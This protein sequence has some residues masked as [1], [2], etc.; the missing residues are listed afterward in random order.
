MREPGIPEIPKAAE[1][2]PIPEPAQA[3]GEPRRPAPLVS[4]PQAAQQTERFPAPI[5][6]PFPPPVAV[7]VPVP[8]QRR[9]SST[10]RQSD[11]QEATVEPS[12]WTPTPEP[13]VRNDVPAHEPRSQADEAADATGNPLNG[14]I[15]AGFVCAGLGLLFMPWLFAIIVFS[16]GQGVKKKSERGS[17]EWLLG[18]VLIGL[19]IL[20][21]VVWVVKRMA[22]TNGL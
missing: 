5:A 9:S 21:I 19:A 1:A 11:W 22:E 10:E 18:N 4:H 7:P 17:G 13:S 2:A 3:A 20:D 15:K 6:V 8:S 14:S 16:I 12:D